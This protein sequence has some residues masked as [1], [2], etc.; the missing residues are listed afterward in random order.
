MVVTDV[1]DA[2]GKEVAAAI[3]GREAARSTYV[4][5]HLGRRLGAPGPHV[6]EHHGRLDV[7]HSNAFA[8]VNKA[9]DELSEAEWDGQMAV[10][11]TAGL[12][13]DEDVRGRCCARP[14]GSVVL[15]SS[16]HALI[17]LPGHAAYAAAKGALCSLGRQLAV[18]YGPEIRVNTVLPGPIL[19]AAWDGIPEADRAAQRRRARRPGRFGSPRRWRPPSPSWPRRTP[20]TS[21]GA[22]LRGRRRMERHEGR[23]PERPR[24]RRACGPTRRNG[25]RGDP[26]RAAELH[27]QTVEDLARRI[28]RGDY[29]P[30]D[31]VDLGR[32]RRRNS[33][34]A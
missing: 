25:E 8:Q 10:L 28:L 17:G 20:P 14:S 15:T 4:R 6:Q 21:P 22:S 18:E 13:G 29:P 5:R 1:D 33:A 3:T 11:L 12:A 27:G 32:L 23:P 7:L 30:G 31:R 24:Y 9:A 2:A 16:V 26:S 19:T 34:S